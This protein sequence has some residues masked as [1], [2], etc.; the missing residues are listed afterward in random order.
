MT[1]VIFVEATFP[2]GPVTFLISVEKKECPLRSGTDFD[3]V[4]E[5]PVWNQER[6]GPEYEQM[7]HPGQTGARPSPHS[8]YVCR[9]FS[10]V[11]SQEGKTLCAFLQ[12]KNN[13]ITLSGFALQS[14][15]S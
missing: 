10:T 1:C 4:V 5:G 13:T 11:S 9:S 15:R 14:T 2:Y 12:N 6:N 7:T 8:Q 3:H